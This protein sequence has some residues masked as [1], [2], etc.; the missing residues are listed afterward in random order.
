[1]PD[2][3]LSEPGDCQEQANVVKA[4]QDKT[5]QDKTRQDN[6]TQDKIIFAEFK[7]TLIPISRS[8]ETFTDCI[9]DL[10]LAEI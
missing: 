4:Q 10:K 7:A 3:S 9:I 6:T 2:K 1:M 5:R 8:C